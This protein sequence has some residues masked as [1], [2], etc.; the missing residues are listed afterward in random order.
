MSFTPQKVSPIPRAHIWMSFFNPNSR[1]RT[2][3][4]HQ[5][6]SRL[7]PDPNNLN[8]WMPKAI[9]VVRLHHFFSRKRSSNKPTAKIYVWQILITMRPVKVKTDAVTFSNDRIILKINFSGHM[10]M[11]ALLGALNILLRSSLTVI[12]IPHK[13]AYRL[14]RIWCKNAHFL[15]PLWFLAEVKTYRMSPKSRTNSC[16]P[17]RTA[18]SKTWKIFWFW[19]SPSGRKC[20]AST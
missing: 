5:C 4:F 3:L 19:T 6:Q 20:S 1:A 10:K 11:N 2:T 15:R 9:T 16:W 8:S 17:D 18:C 12:L 14:A 7:T 13:N